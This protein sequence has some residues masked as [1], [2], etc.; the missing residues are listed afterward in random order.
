MNDQHLIET[1]PEAFHGERIDRVVSAIAGISRSLAKELIVGSKVVV[2]GRPITTASRKVDAGMVVTIELPPPDD[3]T[4]A[5]QVDVEFTVIHEDDDVI[6]VDKP[7]GLVVHPGA[8]QAD[9]TLVN[10]LVRAIRN[11][12]GSARSTVRASCTGSTGEHQACWSLLAA[13]RPTSGWS[14]R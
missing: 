1:L 5:P 6:V 12:C 4:P 10:G 13:R 14:A 11:S 8:G 2:D 9:G 7:A 3:P